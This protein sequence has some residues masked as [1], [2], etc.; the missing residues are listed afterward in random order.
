MKFFIFLFVLPLSL[1]AQT[2]CQLTISGTLF[3]KENETLPG[4]TVFVEELQRGT[5]ADVDGKFSITAL[6]PGKYT[7]SIKYLGYKDQVETVQLTKSKTLNVVMAEQDEVLQEVVVEDKFKTDN[8]TQSVSVLSGKT[9]E[10]AKGRSFGEVLR[11]IPGVGSIQTGPSIFKPVIHGVH[12]QRILILNNGIRHEGQQWGAEHAPE[13]DPFIASNIVV[14]K[15]AGAI[16]YGTDALGGV[17]LVN[18]PALPV[19]AT[20]GGELNLRANSNGR[21]GIVSGMLQ[22]GSKKIQGLG[23]RVQGTG[24]KGGDYRAPDYNLTN[25]G[26]NELNFSTAAGYRKKNGSI[27]AFYSHFKS[28]LG[29][30]RGSV[31]SSVEDLENALQLEPPQG[32]KDFS[33]TIDNPRQEVS[34]DLLKLNGEWAAGKNVYRFQYGFQTN[35]RK[36]FDV[37]RGNLYDIPSIDLKLFT[38]T[39]DIEWAHNGT[40]AD[41]SVGLNGMLQD[42]NNIFGTQRI[43]FIPNFTSASGGVFFIEKIRMGAWIVDAG[44]RYDFKH[45]NVSGY[46]YKNAPYRSQLDFHSMTGTLG[47]SRGLGKYASLS[48]SLGSAWR[49]PHVAE[50]YSF[51]RHQSAGAVEYGL[52]LDGS[53]GVL[54]INKS[55]YRNENALKWVGSLEYNR[56]KFSVEV[57]GYYNYI[58]N[59]IYLKPSGITQTFTGPTPYFNYRQTDASF[60]GLDVSAFYWLVSPLKVTAKASLLRATDET[61]HDYLVFVP[62][63]RYELGLRY[64]Q[65]QHRA[66]KNFYADLRLKY[67]ARQNRTP[68]YLS[69][70]QLTALQ[71]AG[72][73]IPSFDFMEAPPDYFLLNY[74]MGISH[75]IGASRID[76]SAGVDNVLNTRYREFTNRMKYYADDLGRNFTLGV[77][78]I[79]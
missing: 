59:Y 53:E 10:E 12:S 41:R 30:L 48:T 45:Y 26:F 33:Y 66:W 3:S 34:H 37:R 21:S 75:N 2:N 51:G 25:T 17:I 56:D 61:H 76:I 54:D 42:N 43:P 50:L 11:E 23:W 7:L 73:P 28:N 46:D 60:L 57:S 74:S 19:D 79:F 8:E 1:L 36:E 44:W 29:I 9:L 69:M 55:D 24:K 78:Y 68:A 5:V 58:F 38:H 71:D 6:C 14:I 4:A 77:K 39:L 27:E 15:D 16:K 31:T 40:V 52:L 22:G 13:I 35:K 65:K 70:E 32:T 47:A 72:E 49:P 18:P 64:E 63:N 62:S 67:V 20:L